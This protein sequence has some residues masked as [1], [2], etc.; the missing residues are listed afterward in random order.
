M[1]KKF[2]EGFS[3]GAGF[4]LAFILL[5]AA[6]SYLFLPWGYRTEVASAENTN[7]ESVPLLL[8]Q[9]NDKPQFSELST[10][11]KIKTSAAIILAEY[12]AAPNGQMQ[13]IVT[14]IIKSSSDPEFH[15]EIGNEHGPSS[16]YPKENETRLEKI[17]IF[18]KGS[19]PRQALSMAVYGNR[20][21]SLE[22]MRLEDFIQMVRD[23]GA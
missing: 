9:S 20:I 17:L 23:T 12:Q 5:V 13:A 18:F 21:L 11:E 8:P 3:F 10:E 16:Y 14:K 7:K 4:S 22:G 15:Y 19:P 2:F 1:I 6:S